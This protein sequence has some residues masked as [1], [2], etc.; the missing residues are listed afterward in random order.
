MTFVSG[1]LGRH[2][3]DELQTLLAGRTLSIDFATRNDAFELAA[4]TNRG[5][6]LLQLQLLTAYLSD[7]GYRPEAA[8][9]ARKTIDQYYTEFDHVVDG[10][11]ETVVPRLLA[12]GDPR[13]GLPDRS[14]V[15][16]RNLGE[17]KAWLGPQ[18]SG[19]SIEIGLVGDLDIES[20]LDAVA[21]TLGTLPPR[22]PKPP[23]RAERRVAFPPSSPDPIRY[24]IPSQTPKAEVA[25][26]WPTADARDVH[27]TR[28]LTLL[29]DVFADRLRLR[30]RER[31]GAAYDPEAAS[32]P[33]DTFTDYGLLVTKV[34]VA[35]ARVDEVARI[36]LEMGATL[37]EWGVSADELDRAKKPLLTALRESARTNQYWIG[38]VLASC[39]EFPERLDW[40][41]TRESDVAA[42]RK[43]DLDKLAKTYL[44]PGRAFQ[45][46][47][48][49]K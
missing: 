18:L 43:A 44:A 35:P 16:A 38:A 8:R 42:V 21:R 19:G 22:Q 10:P 48:T 24:A 12:N 40:A 17:E 45:I 5:D 25:V 7:P 23:Y 30:L 41:R 39:Q 37:Q 27:R 1:G 15:R 9:T 31:L 49:P 14:I 3:A 26:F 4:A 28:R 33:S 29:A 36:I 6:L 46:I 34:I 20:A 11:F 47:V 32:E 2:S 13:F